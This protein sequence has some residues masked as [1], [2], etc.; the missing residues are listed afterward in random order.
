[1]FNLLRIMLVKILC[2]DNGIPIKYGNEY[3]IE[4]VFAFDENDSLIP[5]FTFNTSVYPNEE[6]MKNTISDIR[7]NNLF[8][9]IEN[10]YLF[11]SFQYQISYMHFMGNT[12]PLLTNYMKYYSTYKLLIPKHSYNNFIINILN[13]LNIDTKNVILLDEK[14]IYTVK[15]FIERNRYDTVPAECSNDHLWIYNTLRHSLNIKP[16][17][18]PI[19]KVYLKKDGIA[20]DKYGNSETGKNRIIYNENELVC[21]FREDGFEIIT[22]GD[23]TIEEKE[24]LLRDI[25]ILVTQLGANC[26][27]LIF[28]NGPKNII[29]LSNDRPFGDSWYTS[30]VNLLNNIQVNSRTFIYPSDWSHADPTNQWNCPYSVNADEIMNYIVS[31]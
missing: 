12:L 21:R 20:N 6:I 9:T 25:K 28:S 4:R 19:R 10:G 18:N 2:I 29:Y 31:I 7:Q 23:K 13:L 11:Y 30:L 17:M 5:N 15:N 22:L 3:G 24:F 1:M 27:N 16:N 14:K 26:G 8:E